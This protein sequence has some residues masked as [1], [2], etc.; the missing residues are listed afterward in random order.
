[1]IAETLRGPS[2]V[3]EVAVAV[4][5]GVLVDPLEGAPCIRLELAHECV[6][7]GPA[8]VLVEQDQ[9]ELRRIVGPVIRTV[10]VE[11]E[12]DELAAAKLVEDLA[13]LGVPKIVAPGRLGLGQRL[14]G[15]AREGRLER[16]RLV[17]RDQAV[18]AEDG[19]E[20]RHPAG[21]HRPM[22]VL[23]AGADPQRRE[24]D[25]A[26]MVDVLELVVRLQHRRLLEPL[27]ERGRHRRLGLPEGVA[28]EQ[29]R[30]GLDAFDRR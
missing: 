6:V 19:Q 20:P 7:G 26:A 27:L 30:P 4:Q 29:R 10:W 12:R 21:R 16:Q 14:Q 9:E 22:Q 17:G 25:E 11:A 18:A 23:L 8:L 2:L 15:G 3:F 13:G 1:V 24:I 28:L 5:V